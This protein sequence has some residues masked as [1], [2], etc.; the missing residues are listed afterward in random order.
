VLTAPSTGAAAAKSSSGRTSVGGFPGAPVFFAAVAG[1]VLLA[2]VLFFVAGV[3]AGSP[4][5]LSF[6]AVVLFFVAV[7]LFCVVEAP[8]FFVGE[9][10]FLVARAGL[11]SSATA[12]STR[13]SRRS[14]RATSS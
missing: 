10:T 2:E 1:R 3:L 11:P 5:T 4:E 8:A 7:E 12:R 9:L 13:A 6:V 14:S